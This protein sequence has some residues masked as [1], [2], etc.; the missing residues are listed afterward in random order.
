[1]VLLL[2]YQTDKHHY[3]SQATNKEAINLTDPQI[4]CLAFKEMIGILTMLHQSAIETSS[5][6]L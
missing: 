2:Q 3:V 4:V 1:M 5:T 6:L